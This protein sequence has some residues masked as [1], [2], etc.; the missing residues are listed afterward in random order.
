MFQA[1]RSPRADWQLHSLPVTGAPLITHQESTDIPATGRSPDPRFAIRR[2]REGGSHAALPVVLA[3]ATPLEFREW[4]AGAPMATG[5]YDIPYPVDTPVRVPDVVLAPVNG[6]DAH[7]YRL[8]YG[9]GY[10]DRT[11]ASYAQ[12]PLCIG[13]G[14]E[15]AR[16]DTIFPRDHDI[17]FDFMVTEV[18]SRQ[19][20]GGRL[21]PVDTKDA[22][23]AA[24]QRLR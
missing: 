22:R 14:F 8:C 9:G 19:R 18:G 20:L 4:W 7:G 15:T 11:L 3:R 1:V 23:A 21:I 10:F 17:P 24:E 16:M 5:V 13:L 12:R 6:F 2:W